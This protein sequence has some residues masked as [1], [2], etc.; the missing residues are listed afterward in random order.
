MPK[1]IVIASKSDD[2][3]ANAFCSFSSGN[4]LDS[5]K[6]LST[7]RALDSY[8]SHDAPIF[9]MGH[10]DDLRKTIGGMDPKKLAE[11]FATA[12]SMEKRELVQDI[13]LI[14]CEAGLLPA[15]SLAEKFYNELKKL[16]FTNAQV[17]A[18]SGEG[19]GMY[20]QVVTRPPMLGIQRVAVGSIQAYV[21]TDDEHG[22]RRKEIDGLIEREKA[23]A[24][25][26]RDQKLVNQLNIELRKRKKNNVPGLRSI[27]EGQQTY[28]QFWTEITKPHNTYGASPK[29][30]VTSQPEKQAG[31]FERFNFFSTGTNS[32]TS[33]AQQPQTT[34]YK[35]TIN[36]EK[37]V[38]ACEAMEKKLTD[39]DNKYGKKSPAYKV[40]NELLD[41]LKP[42]ISAAKSSDANIQDTPVALQQIE[43]DRL[44]SA[45]KEAKIQLPLHRGFIDSMLSACAKWLGWDFKKTNSQE[46]LEA[47][48]DIIDPAMNLIK[49]SPQ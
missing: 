12:V 13:C 5:D 30:Q 39:L 19:S 26:K 49:P 17:H 28:E 44:D 24:K 14:S 32:D 29:A 3:A 33:P 6:T 15:P 27:M 47:I 43:F 34:E 1:P 41:A 20:V 31:F 48:T 22:R 7:K 9:F 40:A 4:K 37:F 25:D 46:K 36:R 45:V 18:V 8:V 42:I 38:N 2:E 23:K 16:G 10:T 35:M 11:K 21:Y